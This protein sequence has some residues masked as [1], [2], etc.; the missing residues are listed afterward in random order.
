MVI[1]VANLDKCIKKFGDI[2]NIDINPIIKW[3]T[4]VVQ[5]EAKTLAPKH[6]RTLERSIKAKLVS[7]GKK[8]A[9]YG[10]VYTNLEYAIYQEFGTSKPH[11]VP[12]VLKD[13]T[14]TGLD[15]WAKDH[16]IPVRYKDGIPQGGLMISGVPRPFLRPALT[17]HEREINQKLQ[18]YLKEEMAKISKT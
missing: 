9:G 4:Q 2:A 8:G 10:I 18:K 14:F 16:G 13:G 11:F 1:K 3:G 5:R 15:K 17:K 7:K 12:Y 6:T